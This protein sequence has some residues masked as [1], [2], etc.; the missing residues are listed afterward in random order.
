[1]PG[2]F[3]GTPSLLPGSSSSL[4]HHAAL[5]GGGTAGG[6]NNGAGA[7][8]AQPAGALTAHS[9]AGALGS[10][11]GSAAKSL[12][13]VHSSA[14]SGLGNPPVPA[15]FVAVGGVGHALQLQAQQAR[16]ELAQQQKVALDVGQPLNALTCSP[17]RTHLAVG[18]K[19]GSTRSYSR[20]LRWLRLHATALESAPFASR[21][22]T[23]VHCVS[24]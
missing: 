17:D 5:F 13:S 3:A 24:P 1:V 14:S 12:F 20:L 2:T 10:G 16:L 23:M 18:G 7:G 11:Q 8:L 19:E 15:S 6:S 22:L 21:L 4:Q 9:G